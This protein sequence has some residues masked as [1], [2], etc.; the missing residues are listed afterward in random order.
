M[1]KQ[2][3]VMSFLILAFINL[4]TFSNDPEDLRD[5]T[6]IYKDYISSLKEL[7]ALEKAR[8]YNKELTIKFLLTPFKELRKE[9]E[10]KYEESEISQWDFYS[11]EKYLLDESKRKSRELYVFELEP[12]NDFEAFLEREISW[13]PKKSEL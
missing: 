11:L 2:I 6:D 5:I 10:L 8:D 13:P 4:V 9:I 12:T 3:K 1:W 7:K